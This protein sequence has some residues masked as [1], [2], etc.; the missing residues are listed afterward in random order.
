MP[1]FYFFGF[2]LSSCYLFLCLFLP[3]D[4]IYEWILFA[5]IYSLKPLIFRCIFKSSTLF[6][7]QDK[8]ISVLFSFILFISAKFSIGINTFIYIYIVYLKKLKKIN[9][10]ITPHPQNNILSLN[11][12]LLSASNC[13]LIEHFYKI[14]KIN[15]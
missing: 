2:I 4:S 7:F 14:P 8:K 11:F 15:K 6:S 9:I 13:P 12:P 5:S 3:Y 1:K 10:K